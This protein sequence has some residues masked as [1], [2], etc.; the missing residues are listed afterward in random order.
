[1]SIAENTR[2]VRL[3]L[4]KVMLKNRV[5]KASIKLEQM[6]ERTAS[7]EELAEELNMSTVEVTDFLGMN[8]RHVSL[9]APLSEKPK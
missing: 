6:L 1:M 5:Q 8:N 2:I 9:D 7:I 3:P 4:N